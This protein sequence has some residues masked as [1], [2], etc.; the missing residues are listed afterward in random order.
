MFFSVFVL[1]QSMILH[2]RKKMFTGLFHGLLPWSMTLN[3]RFCQIFVTLISTTYLGTQA[4]PTVCVHIWV[5]VSALVVVCSFTYEGCE[6]LAC[7][8]F[9]CFPHIWGSQLNVGSQKGTPFM[10]RSLTDDVLNLAH[11]LGR[12]DGLQ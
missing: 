6:I 1:M 11:R 4:I 7:L 8:C 9:H 12:A 3:Q 2:F 10:F 5:W